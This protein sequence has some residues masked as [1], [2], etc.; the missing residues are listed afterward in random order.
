LGDFLE[1]HREEVV[2]AT[3]YTSE[4]M[5]EILPE[6]KQQERIVAALRNVSNETGR[7]LAQVALA[8]L[9]YR[10]I[11]V[12]AIIGARKLSQFRENVASLSVSL[13]PE[14]VKTLDAVS[15]IEL[16]FPHDFYR[17]EMVRTFVYG[18]MRDRILA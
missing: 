6:P 4:M 3:K 14:Q 2:P 13:T 9:R 1:G 5:R 11:P 8:W 17:R 10:D 16:G 12:I 15:Q 18:G 7:S